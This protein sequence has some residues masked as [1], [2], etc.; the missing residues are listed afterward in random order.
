MENKVWWQSKVILVNIMMGIAII[1]MQFSPAMS[2]FIKTYFSEMG[3]G[4]AFI[5]ILLRLF[6]SN[7]QL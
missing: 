2:E 4:W 7:I 5:N 1:V 3:M 6:K